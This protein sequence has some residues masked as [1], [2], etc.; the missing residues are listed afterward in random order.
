MHADCG[1]P[2]TLETVCGLEA[3]HT[4]LAGAWTL[5][6]GS[7]FDVVVARGRHTSSFNAVEL[8]QPHAYWKGE[9]GQRAFDMCGS[10][11]RCGGAGRPGARTSLFARTSLL[12]PACENRPHPG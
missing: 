3:Q 4:R 2:V 1:Q 7:H 8:S 5:E 11:V 12:L 10:R 6:I 9:S